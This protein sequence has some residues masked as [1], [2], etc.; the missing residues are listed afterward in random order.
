MDTITPSRVWSVKPDD[1][2]HREARALAQVSRPRETFYLGPR[3]VDSTRSAGVVL[4]YARHRGRLNRQRD[5][6]GD[7]ATETPKH[8]CLAPSVSSAYIGPKAR[9]LDARRP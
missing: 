7:Q 5:Q 8:S 9:S 6:E 3:Q 2:A 4:A 1:R